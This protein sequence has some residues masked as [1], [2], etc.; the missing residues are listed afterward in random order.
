MILI[1]SLINHKDIKHLFAVINKQLLNIKDLFNANKLSLNVEKTKYP[2]F[3]KPI[4]KYDIP[5]C[6]PKITINNYQRQESNT[7][8]TK[9]RMYQVPSGLI[10]PTLNMGRT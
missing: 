9:A 6:L 1:L 7:I 4:K 10:R 8:N 2:F 3:C 5:L